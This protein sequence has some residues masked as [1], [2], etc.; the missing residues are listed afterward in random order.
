VQGDVDE[1]LLLFGRGH[2]GDRA[3]L[4]VAELASR[5][6]LLGTRQLA[7]GSRHP[8]LLAGGVQPDPRPPAQPVCTRDE[9]RPCPALVLVELPKLR[10]Q[11]MRRDVDPSRECGD[12]LPERLEFLPRHRFSGCGSLRHDAT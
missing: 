7:E 2:A 12:L 9:V 6:Q 3:D 4:R 8:N 10:D 11:G 5:E 1:V